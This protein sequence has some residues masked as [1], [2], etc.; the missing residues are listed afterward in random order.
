MS[1]L[2]EIIMISCLFWITVDLSRIE[3]HLRRLAT[4]EG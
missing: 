4:D 2:G 3:K 1:I